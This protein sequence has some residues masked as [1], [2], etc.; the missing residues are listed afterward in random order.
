MVAL[1]KRFLSGRGYQGV[2]IIPKRMGIM[3]RVLCLAVLL[4]AAP[5]VCARVQWVSDFGSVNQTWTGSGGI[6]DNLTATLRST[7][8]GSSN[9]VSYR[10]RG[11]GTPIPGAAG[12]Q[13]QLQDQSGDFMIID[14][15]TYT[16]GSDILTHDIWSSSHTGGLS[17]STGLAILI[18]NSQLIAADAGDVFTGSIDVCARVSN[19][20][21][22]PISNG[23]AD[24]SVVD[25]TITIPVV[26]LV[27]VGG[28]GSPLS[29]AYNVAGSITSTTFCLGS[30][31]ATGVTVVS[32][33]GDSGSAGQFRMDNQL[34]YTA[35]INGIGL[36]ESGSS[37]LITTTD[38]LSDCLGG[39]TGSS[40]LTVST[41]QAA[42]DNVVAGAYDDILTITITPQ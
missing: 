7:R 29:L 28:L 21:N 41:S 16:P 17:I 13:F 38:T 18:D 15:V 19:Q 27:A 31:S 39:S 33:S 26:P 5:L 34:V 35:S 3:T 25:I 12:S 9:P 20:S 42:Q 10:V 8:G 36:V 23:N 24:I 6:S 11:N 4:L 14:L 32:D 30:N 2:V 22:C 40:S 1:L 37:P